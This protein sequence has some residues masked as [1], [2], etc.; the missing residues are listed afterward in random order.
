MCG[1]S[2]RPSR[3]A[4]STDRRRRN[5]LQVAQPTHVET[6]VPAARLAARDVQRPRGESRRR[7]LE[8][9]GRQR[10]SSEDQERVKKRLRSA[11][12]AE[13]RER[14][15][16][17]PESHRC[18][19]QRRRGWVNA[20]VWSSSISTITAPRSRSSDSMLAELSLARSCMAPTIAVDARELAR[21]ECV[22]RASSADA[23]PSPRLSAAREPRRALRRARCR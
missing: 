17:R 22:P 18:V 23:E 15:Q 11:M 14:E 2:C 8:H 9:A 13:H 5:P 7:R 10:R 3:R 12:A 4:R 16:R 19:E 21:A 20:R 1:A 6:A